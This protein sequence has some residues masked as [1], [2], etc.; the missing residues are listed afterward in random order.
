MAIKRR[1]PSIDDLVI[2]LCQHD[3]KQAE[4]AQREHA[5]SQLA[6]REQTASR[7]NFWNR[8]EVTVAITIL[9]VV[10]LF[11]LGGAA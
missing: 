11:R 9:A 1:K 6:Q 5:I 7:E 2:A 8:I 3:R 4:R 10:E